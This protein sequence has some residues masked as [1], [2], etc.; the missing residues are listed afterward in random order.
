MYTEV[1]GVLSTAIARMHLEKQRTDAAKAEFDKEK[2]DL[3]EAMEQSTLKN[4]HLASQLLRIREIEEQEQ[5]E[6]D[7]HF[8]RLADLRHRKIQLASIESSC[9]A[10]ESSRGGAAS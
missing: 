6:T 2:R 1:K 4:G 5:R 8:Q 7:V 3:S 9:G 10:E